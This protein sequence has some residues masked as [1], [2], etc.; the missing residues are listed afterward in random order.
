M[1]EHFW[2]MIDSPRFWPC[3]AFV[4]AILVVLFIIIAL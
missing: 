3:I 2:A 1:S 4:N